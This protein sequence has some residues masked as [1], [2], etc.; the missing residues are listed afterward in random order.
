MSRPIRDEYG[1]GAHPR[2]VIDEHGR[3]V[4]LRWP[5]GHQSDPGDQRCPSCA[6]GR[7]G[8]SSTRT[9]TRFRWSAYMSAGG[10]ALCLVL[11]VL[12]IRAVGVG[13]TT[14]EWSVAGL[15]ALCLAVVCERF[16]LRDRDL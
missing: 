1:G 9:A 12:E 15:A 4:A 2:P 7:S 5:C 16:A 8:D 14:I 13:R 10:A 3:I 6:A 11:V